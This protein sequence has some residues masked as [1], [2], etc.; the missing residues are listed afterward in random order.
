MLAAAL[1]W[2]ALTFGLVLATGWPKTSPLLA[3]SVAYRAMA[4]GRF[5]EAP[6]SI[7]GRIL[8]PAF[9]RLVSGVSGIN[10]DQ[11]FMAVAIVSLAVLITTTACILKRVTGF[12]ALVL[13]LLFA[14][15]LVENMFGLYYCQDLF[16]AAL[17]GCFFLALIAGR[18]PIASAL[19]FLLFLTRESTLLLALAWMAIAWSES[20]FRL[21]M[22]CIAAT[23]AG[24]T[25]SRIFAALGQPN[26]HHTNELA[27]LALKIPFD[28]ARNLLGI[29]LVPEELKG[30]PGFTC[31]PAV[32]AH[33]PR[34]LRY[35]SARQFGICRPDPFIPLRTLTLW[36]SLFGI[37][38]AMLLAMARAR[39]HAILRAT[40]EWLRLASLYGVLCF[41]VAP[42]VSFW[43]E[44]D[45][46]YAWP[47]FWLA[48]PAWLA[49]HGA[50]R[51]PRI[52]IS[53]LVENLA[54]SWIPYMLACSRHHELVV[55]V[56]LCVALI[57]QAQALRMLRGGNFG[58]D[59]AC[60]FEHPPLTANRAAW[61]FPA[62]ISRLF[63]GRTFRQ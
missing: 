41:F 54:A 45:I 8:H 1:P 38:P 21:A 46:G 33:L 35:G 32:V 39:M 11:A 42:A 10:I 51:A 40:P 19:L 44:R 36:L 37:G 60:R 53:L 9:V 6:A 34:L 15:V 63:A 26:V 56:T 20:K 4:M 50:A 13:P 30:R 2:A 16:Y 62:Q 49:R 57:M 28:S 12:G 61:F 47:L 18:V 14:P 23:A 58:I 31:T 5:G 25:I 59:E 43:L 17:L 27:F 29:I 22:V 3:D 48:V 7:T 52:A 24:L 55:P